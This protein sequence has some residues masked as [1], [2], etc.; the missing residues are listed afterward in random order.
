MWTQ[1]AFLTGRSGQW[2]IWVMNADTLAGTGGSDQRPLFSATTLAGLT[3]QYNGVDER[4]R[5]WR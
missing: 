1:I 5:S 3:L 4:A 2:E